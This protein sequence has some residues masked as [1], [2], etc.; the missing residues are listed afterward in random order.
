M[1]ILDIT[2]IS[3]IIITTVLGL[4]KGMQRQVFG[5]GGVIVGYIAA[6]KLY[7]PVAGLIGDENSSISQIISFISIFILG[8]T[9]VSASGW[10]AKNLMKGIS[11]TW[12]NRTGGALLGL[13]KGFIIVMIIVL[14]VLAFIPADSS[15]IKNSATLPYIASLPKIT[16]GVIPKKIKS[17]YNAKV[18]KLRLKWEKKSTGR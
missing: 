1:N 12:V 5:L 4:W 18:E 11:V 6:T 3:I 2:V 14:T 15:L 8:K 17:K 7:E 10:L 9:G 16:S 13:L